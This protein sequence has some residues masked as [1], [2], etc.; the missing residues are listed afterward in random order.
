VRDVEV[1]GD[2]RALSPLA[3]ARGRDHQYSHLLISS[4]HHL[5]RRTPAGEQGEN[6][7]PSA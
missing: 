6:P 2:Q 1:R 5:A 3:R 4:R 7:V